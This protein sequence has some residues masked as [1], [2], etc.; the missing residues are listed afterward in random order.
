MPLIIKKFKVVPASKQYP[1]LISG[2]D[3]ITTGL[4]SLNGMK[5]AIR[6]RDGNLSNRHNFSV[7]GHDGNNS[8]GWWYRVW[9]HFALNNRYTDRYIIMA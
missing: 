9:T 1:L 6:G 3:E 4:H 7:T 8:G 2:Y 5:S